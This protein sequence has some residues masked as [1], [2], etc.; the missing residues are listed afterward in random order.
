[1]LLLTGCTNTQ[2]ILDGVCKEKWYDWVWYI[3]ED[4]SKQ[5]A[6]KCITTTWQRYTTEWN[7]FIHIPPIK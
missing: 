2:W 4:I 1:M 7:K 6:F 3:E 5:F